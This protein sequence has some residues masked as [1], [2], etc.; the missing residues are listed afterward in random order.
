MAVLPFKPAFH[1][2]VIIAYLP[3]SSSSFDTV[4]C[5]SQLKE[6]EIHPVG[7]HLK[8]VVYQE[9]LS[10]NV[11]EKIRNPYRCQEEGTLN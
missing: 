2:N 4:I 6:S 7:T 11:G 10:P 3:Q 1:F 9:D 5:S 8:E